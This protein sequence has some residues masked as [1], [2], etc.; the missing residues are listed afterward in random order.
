MHTNF[1][2][3]LPCYNESENIHELYNEILNL[4]VLNSYFEIIFVD[5]GSTDGTGAKIDEIIQISSKI[6]DSK[7]FITKLTLP[8]NLGYG[9]GILEIQIIIDFNKF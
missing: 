5:N 8:N 9:G 1:S 4:N 2:I 7:F 6:K 3:I